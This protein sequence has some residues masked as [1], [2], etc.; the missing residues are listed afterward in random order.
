MDLPGIYAVPWLKD[1]LLDGFKTQNYLG[2]D[3]GKRSETSSW[4][5]DIE[6]PLLK[7]F[8]AQ[9]ALMRYHA[10]YLLGKLDALSAE[11][12]AEQCRQ[13][14]QTTYDIVTDEDLRL[15]DD[16]KWS[17]SAGLSTGETDDE[18]DCSIV[19]ASD[20]NSEAPSNEDSED[21]LD[22]SPPT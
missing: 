14:L 11:K 16:E 18:D 22:V 20:C 7:R 12:E 15:S 19:S 5:D 13:I 8:V 17:T 4:D 10:D 21:D 2:Q 1:R 9:H 6:E 3:A